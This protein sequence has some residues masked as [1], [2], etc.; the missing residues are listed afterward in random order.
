MAC[1]SEN[2]LFMNPRGLFRRAVALAAV[3]LLALPPTGA[4]AAKRLKTL[5]TD[6]AGDAPPALDITYLKAGRRGPD[7]QIRFGVEN[8]IPPGG[9]YPDLPGIEWIFDARGRTF[10]AEAVATRG[11]PLF[12]LFELVDGT[13]HQLESPTGTYDWTDGYIDMF[14]P[15][16][17]I[18]AKKGTRI[19]GTDEPE[20]ADVD[21]HVHLFV[22]TYY[23]DTMTTEKD[24]TVP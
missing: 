1:G 22:T 5:G 11:D 10:V 13:A 7:L 2:P 14:V 3:L 16:K 24:F 8:M 9:G 12:F 19:S 4:G 21:S 18:G 20:T 6:P 23:A 15:L 17:T